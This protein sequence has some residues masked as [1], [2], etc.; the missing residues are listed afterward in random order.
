MLVLICNVTAQHSKKEQYK[1]NYY[2]ETQGEL[3]FK[4]Q[5]QDETQLDQMTSDMSLVHYDPRTKTVK[6]WAIEKQ[7]RRFEA[8]NIPYTVPDEENGVNKNTLY[9]IR[10]LAMRSGTPSTLT[11]PLNTYP[12]YT[13]YAQQMQDFQTQ[14]PNL[15]QTFT[16]GA[17][18]EGDKELWFVKIS[19]N[20][21]V[22]E[23]EPKLMYTSTMYP[24][25]AAGY[26]MMLTL[27]DYILTVYNDPGHSD[28]ARVQNLVENAEL[29]INPN[30]NP[31]GTYYNDPSNVSVAQ[32]R[33]GNANNID[34]NR[35]YPDNVDGPNSDGNAYQVE[36]IAFMNLADTN[37]FVISANF[38]GGTELVNYPFDN[39]YA[40]TTSHPED[41]GNN[42]PF[43]THADGDWFDYFLY[44]INENYR[45]F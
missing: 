35:N 40:S 11:F 17:T 43:Y 1:A 44:T 18:T 5:I 39:A 31:D 13:E 36:T 8:K 34:L 21:A 24:D 32:A 30:A 19:D 22:D 3:T 16:I 23:A 27:I 41:P 14:Y 38:H 28:Y 33:R 37:K 20:V 29:W 7:F 25:E 6:A 4:F 9:D 42:G 26:P 2:L 15:V 45:Q 10:P 12:S